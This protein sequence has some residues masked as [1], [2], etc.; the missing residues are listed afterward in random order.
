M[1]LRGYSIFSVLFI[2]NLSTGFGQTSYELTDRYYPIFDARIRSHVQYYKSKSDRTDLA[3]LKNKEFRPVDS[4]LSDPYDP[5]ATYWFRLKAQNRSQQYYLWFFE[6]H[7]PHI[8]YLKVFQVSGTDTLEY[9]ESGFNAKFHT[10]HSNHKNFVFPVRIN[11]SDSSTIYFAFR[12]SYH[13]SLN[14][15]LRPAEQFV[16]Y[17][18]NEY[19][20][21]GLFYGILLIMAIYNAFIFFSTREAIYLYYIVYVISYCFNSFREDGM[22]FQFLWPKAPF[23]NP[24]VEFFAPILLIISFVV[25]AKKFLSLRNYHSGLNR[26]VDIS[27]LLYCAAFTLNYF[28]PD[29]GWIRY[30]YLLPLGLT[31][32]GGFVAWKKGNRSAK[33]FLLG[34]SFLVLSVTIFVLRITNFIPTNVYSVYAFNFGFLIEVVVFSYALGQRLRIEKEE[35]E[36]IDSL[37]IHQLQENEKLKDSLNRELEKKIS[38]RT[39]QLAD[40]LA[41]LK[42]KNEQIEAFNQSLEKDN[43]QLNENISQINKA[44]L[45]LKDLTLEEFQKIYPDE[46]ACLKYL[47]D[48]KWAKSYVCKKCGNK[49]SS[50]GKTP[51]SRRCTR[52][53]YDESVTSFTLFH[54]SKIPITKTFYLVYLVLA[55]REISSHELSAKLDLR[56][57]TC[58]SF[59]KKITESIRTSSGTKLNTK[60]WGRIFYNPAE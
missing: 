17:A 47:A 22:G 13:P 7:D 44:R 45:S 24:L 46:E 43:K 3:E 37:L 56:Q 59:K 26:L 41:E 31:G 34:F 29:I 18:L 35:K 40:A 50:S 54:N 2:L 52:C 19:Y 49:T 5:D 9:K 36:K 48:V 28:V 10:R 15:C 11:S 21:L 30:F 32:Y 38:E 12:N 14:V 53:G 60:E 27:L 55:D 58:W 42:I 6:I 57:K 39:S 20:L 8:Q 1:N 23:I 51:Y 4:Y 25:Y 33:Y 16:D